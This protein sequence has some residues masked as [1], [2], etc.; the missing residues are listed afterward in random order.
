M[1]QIDVFVALDRHRVTRDYQQG[2]Y[3]GFGSDV[4]NFVLE[5][6]VAIF[7]A[8]RGEWSDLHLKSGGGGGNANGP[9]GNTGSGPDGGKDGSVAT[10]MDGSVSGDTGTGNPPPGGG[11][12]AQADAPI[13]GGGDAGDDRFG[14]AAG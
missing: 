8:V 2:A 10:T 14:D 13:I 1:S 11:G 9:P 6:M 4:A 5:R 12:D 3:R 7:A